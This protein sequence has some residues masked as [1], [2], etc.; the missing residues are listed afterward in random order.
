MH[1][2][3]VGKVIYHTHLQNFNGSLFNIISIIKVL[4]L[5]SG[6]KMYKHIILG[7]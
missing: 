3:S 1:W 4:I 7:V 5:R 6:I 2:K